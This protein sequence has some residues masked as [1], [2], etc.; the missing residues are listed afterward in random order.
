M[1]MVWLEYSVFQILLFLLSACLVTGLPLAAEFAHR[2]ERPQPVGL[3]Q[4]QTRLTNDMFR[5]GEYGH[6]SDARVA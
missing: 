5:N 6:P 3:D 2:R 1:M 4:I